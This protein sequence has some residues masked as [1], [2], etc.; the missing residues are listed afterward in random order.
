M[1]H[2]RG[3]LL[4]KSEITYIMLRLIFVVKVDTKMHPKP[5]L[6]L[7]ILYFCRLTKKLSL[8]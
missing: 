6:F 3:H 4:D 1:V 5:N 2:L 8:V 7:T